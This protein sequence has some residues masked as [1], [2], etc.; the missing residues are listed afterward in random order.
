MF[1]EKPQEARLSAAVRMFN[2]QWATLGICLSMYFGRLLLTEPFR[3][4]I[5][6]NEITSMQARLT[7][8]RKLVVTYVDDPEQT[9]VLSQLGEVEQHKKL[10]NTLAHTT[11]YL[12]PKDPETVCFHNDLSYSKKDGVKFLS[13]RR[14]PV[15]DLESASNQVYE[16]QSFFGSRGNFT[17]SNEVLQINGKTRWHRNMEDAETPSA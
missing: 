8:L 5:V 17:T 16:L 3:A 4:R 7:L 15:S 2:A 14:M 1:E 6:W 9:A 13:D 12:D 11:S 10:R